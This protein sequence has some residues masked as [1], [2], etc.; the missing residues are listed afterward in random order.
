MAKNK[1]KYLLL[2]LALALCYWLFDSTVHHLMF[3]E[4]NFEFIPADFNELW[5]RSLVV[6]LIAAFGT[7][8]EFSVRR[9]QRLSA[10]KAILAMDL[11]DAL[12]IILGGDMAICADCRKVCVTR[13]LRDDPAAWRSLED[14]VAGLAVFKYGR[15][16]CPGCQSNR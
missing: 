5:M 12:K 2:G 1:P 4:G 7:Y 6:F 13:H 11:D 14:H 16:R 10:E 8:S 3:H 9:M 15:S